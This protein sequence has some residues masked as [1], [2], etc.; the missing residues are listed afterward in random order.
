[1][2]ISIAFANPAITKQDNKKPIQAD[3]IRAASE[4]QSQKTEGSRINA[5]VSEPSALL[6]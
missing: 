6:T 5:A 4:F 3:M 1:M 2:V